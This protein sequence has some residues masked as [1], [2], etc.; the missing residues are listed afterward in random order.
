MKQDTTLDSIKDKK[1]FFIILKYTWKK[2]VSY[3]G[4]LTAFG[5]PG[6]VV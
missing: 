6:E 2:K 3:H 4:L 1:M 5:G